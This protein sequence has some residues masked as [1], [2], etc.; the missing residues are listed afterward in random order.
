MNTMKECKA[1]RQILFYFFFW[2]WGLNSGTSPWATAPD[3]I[4]WRVFE[5]GSHRTICPGWLWTAILLISASWVARITGVSHWHTAP[6]QFW[7]GLLFL[8]VSRGFFATLC[9]IIS[10]FLAFESCD[11]NTSFQRGG[12]SV[13]LGIELTASSELWLW[14]RRF[15]G[16]FVLFYSVSMFGVCQFWSN[17]LILFLYPWDCWGRK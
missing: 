13:V 3:L 12:V 6:G 1:T 2:Y 5:I 8:F 11:L 9:N 7:T 14:S 15:W 4:L 17:Y 10:H 16:C